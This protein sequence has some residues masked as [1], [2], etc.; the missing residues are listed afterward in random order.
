[1]SKRVTREAIKNFL[2]VLV[3]RVFNIDSTEFEKSC[4]IYNPIFVELTLEKGSTLYERFN[5]PK[6]N[7]FCKELERYTHGHMGID[8][9]S[10]EYTRGNI[11]IIWCDYEII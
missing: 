7:Q 9:S 2:Q 6:I 8:T 11:V 3:W 1:M 4:S 10:S 5:S